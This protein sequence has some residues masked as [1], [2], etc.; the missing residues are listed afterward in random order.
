MT[1]FNEEVERRK[2]DRE[3]STAEVATLRSQ[4]TALLSQQQSLLD[5]LSARDRE[6]SSFAA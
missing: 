5:K 3:G 1:M 2:D 6:V 4:H